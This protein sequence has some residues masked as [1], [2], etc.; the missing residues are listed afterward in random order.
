MVRSGEAVVGDDDDVV[1]VPR[2]KV[3]E[4]IAIA[5]QCEEVAEVVKA[6][7]EIEQCS[8]ERYYPFSELT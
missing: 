6:Q 7:L 1:I 2:I 8:P 5:Q 4:F 3:D